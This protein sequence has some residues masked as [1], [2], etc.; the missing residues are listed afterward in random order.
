[1]AAKQTQVEI[2][3]TAKELQLRVAH[4]LAEQYFSIG[5]QQRQKTEMPSRRRILRARNGPDRSTLS[6]KPENFS[7]E[8][9]KSF[10]KTTV[11]SV[12]KR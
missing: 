6:Y 10:R 3:S 11:N 8:L 5:S 1:M 9:L 12:T 7:T 2:F 4:D